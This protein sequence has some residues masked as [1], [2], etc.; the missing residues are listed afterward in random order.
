MNTP[1]TRPGIRAYITTAA[2][3]AAGLA[4]GTFKITQVSLGVDLGRGANT[5]TL[6]TTGVLIATAITLIAR[7]RDR[8]RRA[9]LD[10]IRQE[11]AQTREQLSA[12]EDK[13]WWGTEG[14]DMEATVDLG[15]VGGNVVPILARR[16]PIAKSS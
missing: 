7:L 13:V 1:T 14:P 6:A 2:V 16:K 4:A 5:A 8:R 12:V 9:E 3:C 15:Q 11:L 10:D